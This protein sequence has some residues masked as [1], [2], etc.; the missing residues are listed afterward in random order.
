VPC[1]WLST[2]V[3]TPSSSARLLPVSLLLHTC[4]SICGETCITSPSTSGPCCRTRVHPQVSHAGSPGSAAKWMTIASGT[5]DKELCAQNC[6]MVPDRRY[7]SVEQ[8]FWGPGRAHY[9]TAV[10]RKPLDASKL[11]LVAN[12]QQPSRICVR[13]DNSTISHRR[14]KLT[15][16]AE[17]NNQGQPTACSTCL[18]LVTTK[19][20]R[21]C[22]PCHA[23]IETTK[24]CHALGQTISIQRLYTARALTL[25]G[26]AARHVQG[27]SL[28]GS[29]KSTFRFGTMAVCEV[30][31]RRFC[32]STRIMPHS[33]HQPHARLLDETSSARTLAHSCDS[34]SALAL[35]IAGARDYMTAAPWLSAQRRLVLNTHLLTSDLPRHP[36]PSCTLSILQNGA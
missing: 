15:I 5:C 9:C 16:C 30:A 8:R 24:Q 21:H 28:T 18:V 4:C 20:V 13:D 22:I 12:D 2:R 26:S 19:T 11:H 1:T 7:L 6:I 10:P 35:V 14:R 31:W 3:C 33:L 36:Y 23:P 34:T 29:E 27:K 17:N 32:R 25:L